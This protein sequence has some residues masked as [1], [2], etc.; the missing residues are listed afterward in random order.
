MITKAEVKALPREEE[1]GDI[2]WVCYK[3]NVNKLGA[4][5]RFD[6]VELL[7]CINNIRSRKNLIY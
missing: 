1:R 6:I 3:L 2:S 4:K 7:G 5:N